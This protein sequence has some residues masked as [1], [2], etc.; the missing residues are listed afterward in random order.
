MGYDEARSYLDAFTSLQLWVL[1]LPDDSSGGHPGVQQVQNPLK[2]AQ[3]LL[4]QDGEK[5][6]LKDVITELTK[7]TPPTTKENVK[8][9]YNLPPS[10]KPELL[11]VTFALL[12]H[13]YCELLEVG[14]E[15]TAH[16]L[17]DA[18]QPVYDPLYTTEYRDLFQCTTT[19]D[20]MRLNSHN[21]QHMEALN[22]LKTILVQVASYQLKRE[23]LHAQT[24]VLANNPNAPPQQTQIREQKIKEYDR[25]I[26]ILKQKY[27]ELSQRACAAFAKMHDLPFLRR[28]RAVRWQLTLSAQTYGILSSFMNQRDD[29]LL[30][31]STLLQTKCELH[32]ERREPLPFT[33]ACV[34]EENKRK[35]HTALDLNRLDIN[36]A[37]PTVKPEDSN[38]SLNQKLP[39]PKFE[40]DKEYE[41]EREARKDKRL[42]KFNRSLL[43][44]GFRRLEALERKREYEVLPPSIKKRIKSGE[45]AAEVLSRPMAN[46]LEP[47][48]LLTTL[49]SAVHGPILRPKP[50]ISAPTRPTDASSIWDEAGIGLC[51]AK[52]C[53]PDGRRIAVGC[54]D[55]SV[56]IYDLQSKKGSAEPSHVLLGHKNGF[57]VFDVDW[58]RDGRCLLS[59]G[60]DGSVRLWDTMAVGPFGEVAKIS[61]K[62]PETD[63]PASTT[64][65]KERIG[66]VSE[67]SAL[68]QSDTEPMS[69]PGL[70][71]EDAPYSSGTALAVYRGHAPSSPIWSVSC[72]PSGYYFA[73]A[74][75]D[76]TA[77]LWTT[78][79]P[80]P[81]RLFTGH[82]ASNVN[83][84][85][86][87]P[88]C[89]Y[90]ITGSDD[91]TCRLWDIQTG[92]TVRLMSG[93][94]AGINGVQVSPG[95]RFAVGSDYSGVVHMWDLGNGKKITEFRSQTERTVSSGR[96]VVQS[97]SFSACGT[98]L[99]T[100]GDDSC[101][102][103]WDVRPGTLDKAPVI[104]TPVKSFVAKRTLLMDVR[105]TR[106]NL[107]L[108]VGK[109][110][111]P[112][113][114]AGKSS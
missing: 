100:A 96:P 79:R 93:C 17:R 56:R 29:S 105:F 71:P 41:N 84:V 14:M 110:V 53:P 102:R 103:V 55:A 81:V 31:M 107:L 77:R 35:G 19:E 13:T 97:M 34:L 67:T 95:G 108:S 42:V 18:F 26:L 27:N 91:K 37:A 1:S 78:D 46:P 114:L 2:R 82:T 60:G 36:W 51:C 39:Y 6:A 111:T 69:V 63:K 47:S 5:P 58:N 90:I 21:S 89:N 40:L 44:N 52:L 88:N 57:S 99:A 20:T 7:G 3:A 113:P 59:A 101:V 4:Q 28:A 72:S 32:I 85:N 94:Y 25:N 16:C 50:V 30:A 66:A 9:V 11:A 64:I 24:A 10:V 38:L 74:G 61:A 12:V 112:V 65:S 83:C 54:D 8:M 80:I 98:A 106:R 87:H 75:A 23:E 104:V 92:R 86:W 68:K 49:T 109:I 45:D 15:S 62:E 76:A 43:V 73:T 70:R 33:P 22:A 48:I